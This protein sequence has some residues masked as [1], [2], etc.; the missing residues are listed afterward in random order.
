MKFLLPLAVFQHLNHQKRSHLTLRTPVEFEP[1]ADRLGTFLWQLVSVWCSSNRLVSTLVLV[2]GVVVHVLNYV[3]RRARIHR[4]L[5]VSIEDDFHSFLCLHWFEFCWLIINESF[6]D[7][8]DAARL[9][10]SKS[11]SLWDGWSSLSFGPSFRSDA[12]LSFGNVAEPCDVTWRSMSHK[13]G[14]WNSPIP[15]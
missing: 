13:S 8:P 4:T 11:K 10:S 7:L 2:E 3:N 12:G 9:I 6:C 14:K 1:L 15:I 5:K